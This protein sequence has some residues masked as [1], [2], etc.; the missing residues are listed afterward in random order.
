MRRSS[1]RATKAATAPIRRARAEMGMT[2]VVVVKSPSTSE[3]LPFPVA[4]P[5]PSSCSVGLRSSTT[6]AGSLSG[7]LFDE[8]GGRARCGGFFQQLID[9]ANQFVSGGAQFTDA[10]PRNL[11]EHALAPRKERNQDAATV[12]A[13]ARAA[14]VAV[15]FEA[16]DQFYDAVM[17]QSQAFRECADGGFFTLGEP[18]HS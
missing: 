17:L 10:V 16:V 7:G 15:R 13:A 11:F 18:A 9:G 5:E 4:H 8:I 6:L 2:R 12:F 3:A 14:H 1:A